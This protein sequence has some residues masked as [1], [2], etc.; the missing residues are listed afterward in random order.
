M[1]AARWTGMGPVV[2]T[3]LA[4]ATLSIV[5]FYPNLTMA[6]IP[7]RYGR[8]ATSCAKGPLEGEQMRG[9]MLMPSSDYVMG[10]AMQEAMSAFGRM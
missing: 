4:V 8:A 7:C 3:K 10:N 1:V 9:V 6:F 5:T 2:T